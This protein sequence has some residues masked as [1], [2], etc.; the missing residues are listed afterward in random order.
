MQRRNA[1]RFGHW[2]RLNVIDG[3]QVFGTIGLVVGALTFGILVANGRQ[4]LPATGS[5][6][7]LVLQTLTSESPHAQSAVEPAPSPTPSPAATAPAPAPS[8][9]RVPVRVVA[10]SRSQPPAPTHPAT[11]TPIPTPTPTVRPCLYALC[12]SPSPLP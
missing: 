6:V 10:P 1:R 4:V 2:A 11:P 3:W 5:A 12:P 7:R 9:P 8:A